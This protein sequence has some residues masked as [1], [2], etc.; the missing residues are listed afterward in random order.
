MPAHLHL[1]QVSLA[2]KSEHGVL[3]S[4]PCIVSFLIALLSSSVTLPLFAL[5]CAGV[6]IAEA[7][8]FLSDDAGDARPRHPDWRHCS[9]CL[10]EA[11]GPAEK[12]LSLFLFPSVLVGKFSLHA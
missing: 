4:L 1:V 6:L 8:S 10:L 9:K 11:V 5:S 7:S 12:R 2:G 3:E